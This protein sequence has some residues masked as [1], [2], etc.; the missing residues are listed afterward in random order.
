[1]AHP[2]RLMTHWNPATKVKLEVEKIGPMSS[3][4]IAWHCARQSLWPL[5]PFLFI[6]GLLTLD[7]SWPLLFKHVHDVPSS[8]PLWQRKNC[9]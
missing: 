9:M 4:K 8:A 6:K 2:H 1:M 3:P 5:L 7:M